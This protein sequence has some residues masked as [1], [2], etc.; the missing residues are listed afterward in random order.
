MKTS[1]VIYGPPGTG[2]ST[3]IMRRVR[4]AV[5]G[6]TAEERI[7][8]LSFT[9]AA[10][11]EIARRSGAMAV[12]ASTLHSMAFRLC[13][14]SRAQ[15]VDRGKLRDFT[16]LSGI[17]VTGASSHEQ[18]R[19][20]RGDHYLSV[21]NYARATLDDDLPGVFRRLNPPEGTIV[22]MAYFARA[23]EDWKKMR[24]FVDFADMIERALVVGGPTLDLMLLDEAQDFSPA[25]W[26]LIE[27]WLPSIDEVVLALDD[28]QAIHV[29]SGAD[30]EGGP[31]FERRYGSER[32]VLGR[33]YRLPSRIHELAD[34]L[35]S[36]VRN[37]VQKDFE[38]RAEGG[39]ILVYGSLNAVPVPKPTEDV[40]LLF[41]NHSLRKSLEE[42]LMGRRI[43]FV[44]SGGY[45]GPLQGRWSRAIDVW[46][47]AQA[48]Y[49]RSGDPMLTD[50]QAALLKWATSGMGANLLIS[51]LSRHWSEVLHVPT[52]LMLYLRGIEHEHGTHKPDTR[53]RMSTIHGAKGWEAD[54]VILLNAMGENTAEGYALNRD[55]EIRVFYVGVTRA[56]NRLDIVN[57]DNAMEGLR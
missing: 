51:M 5:D 55:A 25:Q 1:T 41:R 26:R 56:R 9:R 34:R 33:S 53:V 49:E 7:A 10:A 57:G 36:R 44:T 11:A 15:V 19:L 27:H 6:G 22:E 54:R 28:D 4:S 16:R 30:P 32:V 12:Q 29:Y 50:Q 13:D 23:Y 31:E 20:E 48:A 17:E 40:L 37:R 18:E 2:K 39:E 8:V 3:E 43:P 46:K 45:P 35:I 42:W 47:Q 52:R 21:L 24:G 14:F 38:P